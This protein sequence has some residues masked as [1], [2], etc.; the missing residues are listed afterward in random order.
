MPLRF[1]GD[2]W[3][4]RA[5]LATKIDEPGLSLDTIRNQ[6]DTGQMDFDIQQATGT[7]RF[8]PLARLSL[9]NL[10]PSRDDIAFDPVLHTDAEVELVPH[11]LSDF[12]RAAYRRSRQGRDADD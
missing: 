10:D 9:R 7:G 1:H 12:R 3:W 6:I 4:V 8:R 2:V 5:R 11:W